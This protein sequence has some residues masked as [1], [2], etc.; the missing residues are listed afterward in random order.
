MKTFRLK[1]LFLFLCSVSLH[2]THIEI[3]QPI[4]PTL[5]EAELKAYIR[6]C[7]FIHHYDVD[8][9]EKFVSKEPENVSLQKIVNHFSNLGFTPLHRLLI[10]KNAKLRMLEILLEI[11]ADPNIKLTKNINHKG[12]FY[13]GWTAVHIAVRRQKNEAFF[14]TLHKYKGNFFQSDDDE[15]RPIDLVFHEANLNALLWLEKSQ[16]FNLIGL[17]I[18]WSLKKDDLHYRLFLNQF[19]SNLRYVRCTNS[20]FELARSL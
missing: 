17:K 1:I 16:N 5:D 2:S 3:I 18:K 15:W 9:L 14:E 12:K 20:Y 10:D 19:P 8:G 7:N 4:N 6:L 11:G 13:R